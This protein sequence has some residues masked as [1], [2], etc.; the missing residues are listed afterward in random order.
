MDVTASATGDVYVVGQTSGILP[1]QARAGELDAFIRKYNAD[2]TE[3]WTRQFG[4][5][6]ASAASNVFLGP[7]GRVLVAGWVYGA[8]PGQTP[9]GEYDAFLRLYSAD[10]AEGVTRQSGTPAHDR[11]LR[12]S[13][14]PPANINLMVK[15][16]GNRAVEP[17]AV[18]LT[19]L[20]S[21]GNVLERLS[22]PLSSA[23]ELYETAADPAGDLYTVGLTSSDH[24]HAI[25]R[26]YDR[27]LNVIWMQDVHISPTQDDDAFAVDVAADPA[28]NAYVAGRTGAGTRWDAF[29]RKYTANGTEVWT[30]TFSTGAETIAAALVVDASQNVYVAGQT[31]GALSGQ[32]SAGLNDAFIAKLK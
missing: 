13:I 30:Q 1:G 9:A 20:D 27:G 22:Q 4:G 6:R 8:L 23:E 3:A 12:P 25:L 10:G 32:T 24:G 2:G 16:G 11:P 14:D 28:R 29:V 26:K 31:G 7:A 5:P 18:G 21:A 15:S 17:R 19:R